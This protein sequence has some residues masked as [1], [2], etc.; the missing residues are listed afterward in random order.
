MRKINELLTN[1]QLL[2][3]V[4]LYF[5]SHPSPFHQAA[6]MRFLDNMTV[7]KKILTI[8]I[9]MLAAQI[10]VAWLSV[11]EIHNEQ[12]TLKSV[13]A[14][15]EY[16]TLNSKIYTSMIR[17]VRATLEAVLMESAEKR[18]SLI[19]EAKKLK[20]ETDENIAAY[21]AVASSHGLGELAKFDP[22]YKQYEDRTAAALT[23]L[24]EGRLDAATTAIMSAVEPYR[25]ASKIMGGLIEF[26]EK[27]AEDTSATAIAHGEVT[28]IE[29][30]VIC[31]IVGI[32][33]LLIGLYQAIIQVSRPI[34]KITG[35]M[36]LLASGDK[37]IMVDGVQRKDEI[38]AMARALQVFK[39]NALK[40]EQM[41]REQEEAKKKSEA[42]RRAA[43]LQMA[44]DFESKVGGIVQTVSAAATEMR[45]SASTL[46]NTADQTSKQST[47][48]AAAAEEAAT[49]VQTV[50]A[51]AEEL[52]ASITEI[53]RRVQE[54]TQVANK[55]VDEANGTSKTMEE[56]VVSA[57]KIG[58]VVQLINDIASQ[59]NLLA[60]N[61]TIEAARAGEA[62]KGFAVVASEV[63]NLANQTA[64]AT[65]EISGQIATIQSET[66][67]AAKAIQN[68]GGTIGNINRIATTIASAVEEQGAATQEIAR[69]VQQA[70]AGTT[71]VTTNIVHVTQAAGET[72]AAA[73]ELLS[74][75]GELSTQS[76]LLR[77][78]VDQF[79]A[80][81][82]RG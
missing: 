7:I 63:K 2:Y 19:E 60:L 39:D 40:V 38:G 17:T 8:V 16:L 71:E 54:A 69:N 55:A 15:A 48:V 12:Q 80:G 14:T 47:S 82:R 22:L 29:I 33:S 51:A 4:S 78:Q 37:T 25:A 23:A 59:T 58:T 30:I 74:A 57:Q 34:K 56:L 68:I 43:L 65:E 61:A 42:D 66:T 31:I 36:E 18:M 50:A 5:L 11:S 46:N 81:V 6:A 72:G 77:K 21:R 75:S 53:S 35:K 20:Q 52:S 32:L 79:I 9:F 27:K 1:T 13:T 28:I 45:A 76:E 3:L 62:G 41:Q 64:K 44:D 26:N 10:G 49:N 24:E 67:N 73:G 70:A